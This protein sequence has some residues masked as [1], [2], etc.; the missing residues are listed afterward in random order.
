MA[1]TRVKRR[2]R[3]DFSL[4]VEQAEVDP[5][6]LEAFYESGDYAV[7]TSRTDPRC[8]LIA[9]TGGGKSAALRRLEEAEHGHV[10]RIVPENLSLPYISNLGVMKYLDGLEVHLDPF[11]IALWKHVLLVELLKHRYNID[12]PGAKTTFL[13]TLR[14]TIA[15]DSAKRQALDYLDEF[16]DRFWCETDERV[17]DIIEKFERR[18][19]IDGN[20]K[21]DVP[22]IGGIGILASASDAKVSESKSQLVDRFQRIVNETQL[23]RLNKM[24]E[25]LDDDVLNEQH[26][27]YVIIDDLDRD[28]IDER[29]S[30][31]LIRCLFRA[32]QDLKRVRN[33][34]ILVA[35]RTNIFQ[36][37][38]FSRGGGQEEKLRA[39]VLSMRWTR[40]D[41]LTM[42][43]ERVRAVAAT[44]DDPDL[45]GLRDLL[46]RTNKTRGNPVDFILDRTLMRPR[47]AI[48]FVN[49]ALSLSSGRT[50]ISWETL[51]EAESQYSEKRL[52]ALR[53]EWKSTYP[54]IEQVMD[55]FRGY[56]ARMS[57]DSLRQ[58]LDDAALVLAE[59]TFPGVS[60][61]TPLTEPLWNMPS[62]EENWS[63]AYQPLTSLFYGL[64]LI[65]LINPG[66]TDAIYSYEA[67]SL[68]ERWSG[69]KSTV[70]F[71]I[72]PAFQL[73][74][75]CTT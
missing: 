60:W 75:E 10:V 52:L 36:E 47:D 34:K 35:L 67:P 41:L 19:G 9:R 44:R 73:A 20:A 18:I 40:V 62:G 31:A 63:A 3:S 68:I 71:T 70:S 50:S 16:Q 12:T 29:L 24:I 45:R 46:P 57:R 54:G 22:G 8:F 49:E 53:D 43:D 11:F 66:K 6:L 48:S 25:V 64:G 61:L 51:R 28:W 59:P 17:H 32:V 69:I 5:L 39:L 56:P 2:L 27:T 30:N 42:L 1:S 55:V 7:V 58:R 74:L 38:S 72:H 14:Q 26:F 21:V 33:L 65:G 23:P 37:L 13:S 15:R 4:G